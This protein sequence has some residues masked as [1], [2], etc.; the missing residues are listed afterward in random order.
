MG[1]EGRPKGKEKILFIFGCPGSLLVQG[2]LIVVASLIADEELGLKSS[3]AV[4]VAAPG[5]NYLLAY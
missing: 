5:L 4:V 2:L 1:R 3:R